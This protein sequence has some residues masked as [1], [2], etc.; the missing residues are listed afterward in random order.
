[1]KFFLSRGI[2]V[3]GERHQLFFKLLEIV[4]QFF[5]MLTVTMHL[6]TNGVANRLGENE[7]KGP[8]LPNAVSDEQ[9]SGAADR[10]Q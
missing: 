3:V 7:R 4:L 2:E 10:H 9:R 1:M 8:M 5:K 6:L